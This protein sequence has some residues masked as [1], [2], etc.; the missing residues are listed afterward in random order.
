VIHDI[1]YVNQARAV[2]QEMRYRRR[3]S[4]RKNK[5]KGGKLIFSSVLK[6]ERQL[7]KGKEVKLCHGCHKVVFDKV[8]RCPECN[9]LLSTHVV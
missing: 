1:D 9:G 6:E 3:E 4:K 2:D 8:D 7:N 5:K